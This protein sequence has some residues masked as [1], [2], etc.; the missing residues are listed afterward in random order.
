MEF[1]DIASLG[2]TYRYV[3]KIDLKFKQK[4]QEFGFANS[5]QSKQGKGVPNPPKKGQIKYGR[6][7]Q[8]NLQPK[9]GNENSKKDMGKWCDYHKIPWHNI[10]ECRSKNSLVAE[11]KAFVSE[12]D[13]DSESNP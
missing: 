12:A 8:S 9:K 1:M 10:E 4:R 5:S 3:V 2:A 6:E 7:N 11:L 13:L